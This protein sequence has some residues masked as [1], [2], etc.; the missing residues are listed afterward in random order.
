MARTNV[1]RYIQ[2]YLDSN[3]EIEIKIEPGSEGQIQTVE[4]ELYPS[5]K[6]LSGML[7]RAIT[8]VS[9]APRETNN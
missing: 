5:E 6:M 8:G 7:S 2:E 1:G 3:P 4:M 9:N